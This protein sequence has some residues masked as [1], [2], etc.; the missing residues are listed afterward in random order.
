MQRRPIA[1]EADDGVRR[2][3]RYCR[4]DI[5]LKETNTEQIKINH[6]LGSGLQNI[7]NTFGAFQLNRL[8]S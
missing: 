3:G 4:S 8:R 2:N 7:M 5:E 1:K 6:H